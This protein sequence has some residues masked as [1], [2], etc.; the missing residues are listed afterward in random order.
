MRSAPWRTRI[1]ALLG[2]LIPLPLLG[3]LWLTWH[4]PQP[5]PMP[6]A[7][8]IPMLSLEQRR[9]LLTYRRHCKADTE[10]DPPLGCFYNALSRDRYCMDSICD[11]DEHCPDGFACRPVKTFSGTRLI[12]TCI[13]VGERQEGERCSI[14]PYGT[15][16]AC[17]RGLLCQGRCGRPCQLDEPTSCPE[18]FFCSEG[19]QGPPSCLPTCEG[20]TCPEGQQCISRGRS[21]SICARLHGEDCL[22]RPCPSGQECITLE[23]YH[24]PGE[25]WRECRQPCDNL[26]LP[27]CP[28]G[29]VCY[30]YQC[31]RTCDPEAPSSCAPGFTCGR[32]HDTEPW[33]C[34]PE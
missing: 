16:E 23:P 3:L 20:R 21:G 22:Q 34:R 24:R 8:F 14:R 26:T 27:R 11:G 19:T 18:G 33:R 9:A 15:Q 29:S 1:A 2:I 32:S 10:C 5:Q 4:K 31:I 12:R 28:E 7:N 6:G 30:L 13:L 25:L 17:M